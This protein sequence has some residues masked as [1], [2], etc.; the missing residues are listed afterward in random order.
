MFLVNPVNGCFTVSILLARQAKEPKLAH[1]ISAK[2]S[3]YHS[4][5]TARDVKTWHHFPLLEDS[6]GNSYWSFSL[7]EKFT[8]G[9]N[10]FLLRRLLL[11]LSVTHWKQLWLTKRVSP[12][13]PEFSSYRCSCVPKARERSAIHSPF[14]LAFELKILVVTRL[15][16]RRQYVRTYHLHCS[17]ASWATCIR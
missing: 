3:S 8:V 12:C 15:S 17:C 4:T 2:V 9:I 6:R 16:V 10:L 13:H 14:W 11:Y 1:I 5:F 7:H